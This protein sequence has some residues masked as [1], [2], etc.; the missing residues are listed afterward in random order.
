MHDDKIERQIAIEWWNKL[1]DNCNNDKS[2]YS[3]SYKY[4]DRHWMSLTGREIEIIYK[5]QKK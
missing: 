3:L 4:F 5:L 2:K 1:S